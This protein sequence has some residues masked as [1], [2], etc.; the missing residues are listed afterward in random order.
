[1]EAKK[2]TRVVLA[3]AL[4]V[5]ALAPLPSPAK[6][7]SVAIG[8]GSQFVPSSRF[9]DTGDTVVWTHR[10]GET[11]HTV[12][13]TAE[14]C[15]RLGGSNCDSSPNSGASGGGCF[16]PIN[17]CLTQ[18]DTVSRSFSKSGTFTYYC[19]VH[20]TVSSSGCSGMCGEI[21]AKAPPKTPPTTPPSTSA[22]PT[23]ASP[24]G[25]PTGTVSPTTT[26]SPTGTT[27]PSP[28]GTGSPTATDSPLAGPTPGGGGG[29]GGRVALAILAT[30]LL[31]GSGYLVYR[32]FIARA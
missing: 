4:A 23:T 13:F 24:T 28:A 9:I 18:G 27:A 26:A 19:K 31:G 1:M 30:L 3:S 11:P 25:S 20:A 8:P 6:E 17:D 16:L 14:S 2:I 29:S 10:D 5:A 32:N 7:R 22:P 15:Q 21:V 12:T